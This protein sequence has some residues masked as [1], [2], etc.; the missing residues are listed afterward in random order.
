MSTEALKEQDAPE[1]PEFEDDSSEQDIA[2]AKA[3]GWKSPKDWKGEPPKNGFVKASEFLERGKTIMPI[4]QSQLKKEREEKARLLDEIDRIKRES[5][6]KFSRLE[7]MS[8]KALTAQRK[9]L[10]DKYETLKESVIETGDKAEYK[11]IVK[12]EKE[13]LKE[14]DEAAEEKKELD[15]DKPAKSQLPASMKAVIDEWMEENASWFNGDAEMNAVANTYHAKLLKEQ[16]GL[17]IREN[18]EKVRAR[19]E[20]LFPE[21]FGKAEDDDDDTPRRSSRVEGGSR[22]AGGGGK[23]AWSRL[24]ADAQKQADRFI[25]EDGLFLEKGETAEKNLQA[26]RDRY[27]KQYL[28]E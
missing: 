7:R 13:A 15:K 4:V 8:Q 28:G 21:K 1:T 23:S 22:N 14:F 25:K 10:E 27:A 12:E 9:Q 5:E 20:K 11:R 2:E 19:V 3:M 26:A 24:P 18:L 6:D 16:P 17:S